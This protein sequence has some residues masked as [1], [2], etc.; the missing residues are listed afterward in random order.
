MTGYVTAGVNTLRAPPPP[1]PPG[2]HPNPLPL[3]KINSAV[4]FA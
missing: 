1:P 2:P 3:P 4:K